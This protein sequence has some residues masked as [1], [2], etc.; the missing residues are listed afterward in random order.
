MSAGVVFEHSKFGTRA[1]ITAPWSSKLCDEI[2]LRRPDEL[3]LN[4]SKGWKGEHIEFVSSFDWLQSFIIIDFSMSDVGPIHGLVNLQSLEISTYCRTPIEFSS[5]PRL[6]RCSLEWRTGAESVFECATLQDLFINQYKGASSDYFGQLSNLHTL[7]VLNSPLK[8]I[9]HF[10]SLEKLR[11]LRLAN[12]R[13]LRSLDGIGNLRHLTEFTLHN[14]RNV[15]SIDCLSNI[16]SL[17]A[18]YLLN[19]GDIESLKPIENLPLL[20]K[21]IFYES[22]N[23]LDGDLSF[24]FANKNI[25]EVAFQDR[26]HYSHKRRDFGVRAE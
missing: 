16:T 24:A 14:C 11:S 10:A 4:T 3:E 25:T 26:K 20:Q 2:N 7:G 5:F 1:V 12:L 15:T 22:T 23:I 6:K 17:K 19:G 9:I 21:L 13:Q 18:L 8:D